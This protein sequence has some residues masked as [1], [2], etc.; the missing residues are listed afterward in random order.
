MVNLFRQFVVGND[1]LT[2]TVKRGQCSFSFTGFQ[3]ADHADVAD[4]RVL[5]K[6]VIA[7]GDWVQK[8]SAGKWLAKHNVTLPPMAR[9]LAQY[10]FGIKLVENNWVI[11]PIQIFSDRDTQPQVTLGR[12]EAVLKYLSA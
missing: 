12:L 6:A 4:L 11:P 8:E 2:A 1:S 9:F 3:L 5:L 10:N 7:A